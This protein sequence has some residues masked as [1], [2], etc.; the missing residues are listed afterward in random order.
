[1]FSKFLR[2]KYLFFLPIGFLFFLFSSKSLA[3]EIYLDSLSADLS[4][5][6]NFELSV[7]V[8]SGNESVN[9]V[10]GELIFDQ[11]FFRVKDL[12]SA[13]SVINFWV[14]N[15]SANNGI[16]NFSGIIP[17]GSRGKNLFI[18]KINFEPL[19]IGESII[20][21]KNIELF[22]NDGTGDLLTLKDF[23]KSFKIK[24]N[25]GNTT[26]DLEQLIDTE[27]PESFS[28]EIGRDPEIFDNQYFLVFATQ[29][30]KSGVDHYEI[31]EGFWGSFK[32]VTSPYL[33]KDQS[34]KKKIYIKAVDRA[35]NERV[36]VFDFGYSWYQNYYLLGIIGLAFLLVFGLLNK[37]WRKKFINL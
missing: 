32:V 10:S 2:N 25:D 33:L 31:R 5:G 17:G 7:F 16:V 1:M 18:F 9:A 11:T 26:T 29:D 4:V 20:G 13:N 30:K 27:P 21:L 28:P 34:L 35:A 24:G 8:D 12:N 22:K 14:E 37:K 23:S 19:K 15:P 36:V 3:A 6:K